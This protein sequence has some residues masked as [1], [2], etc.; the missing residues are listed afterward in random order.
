[1]RP[2]SEQILACLP[3]R[4]AA[5]GYPKGLQLCCWMESIAMSYCGFKILIFYQ[6]LSY[7]REDEK[8]K[9]LK[10]T[11]WQNYALRTILMQQQGG[12]VL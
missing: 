4:P 5:E 9:G 12:S 7:I 11:Q 10:T 3:V 2:Q 6:K 8:R 1:M